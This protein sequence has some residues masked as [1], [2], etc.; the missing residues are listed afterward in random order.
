MHVFF[1][2]C[3][4]G[5]HVR[6]RIC[7]WMQICRCVLRA[8]MPLAAN[9]N[10]ASRDAYASLGARFTPVTRRE[11]LENFHAD[12]KYAPRFESPSSP[13]PRCNA[14]RDRSVDSDTWTS[15]FFPSPSSTKRGKHFSRLAKENVVRTAPG[16][17]MV[18]LFLRDERFTRG[19]V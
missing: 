12:T 4:S 15:F 7:V 19:P 13:R 8:N 3:I 14:R 6:E 16:L 1:S 5:N 17:R 18:P 10:I 9:I 2:P 11:F